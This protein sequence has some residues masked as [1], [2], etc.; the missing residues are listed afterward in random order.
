MPDSVTASRK[1]LCRSP[2][3]ASGKIEQSQALE[4]ARTL[5]REALLLRITH[6]ELEIN[7]LFSG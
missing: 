3:E 5:P 2:L 1:L 7:A 4:I 6:R